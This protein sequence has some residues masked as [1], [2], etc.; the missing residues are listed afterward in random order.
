MYNTHMIY[1][2]VKKISD[3]GLTQAEISSRARVPQPR[4]SDILSKK[5]QTISYESGKRLEGLLNELSKNV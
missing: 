1:D 2:I 4:I 3:F 5:Q